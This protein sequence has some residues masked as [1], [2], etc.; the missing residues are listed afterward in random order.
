M[1]DSLDAARRSWN[2]S[3]IRSRDT[4]PERWV[5]SALHLR[6]YRFRLHVRNLPGTPDIVLPRYRTAVQVHGCFWH[7]HEGCRFSYQPRS[8]VRFWNDKFAATVRRDA[9]TEAEL[10]AL[11]WRVVVVWECEAATPAKWIGRLPRKRR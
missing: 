9:R 1:T 4:A 6:G 3:R 8:R 2:M 5:R 10:E 7:R 11:G